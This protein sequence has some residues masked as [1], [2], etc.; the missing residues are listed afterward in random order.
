MLGVAGTTPA[1]PGGHGLLAMATRPWRPELCSLTPGTLCKEPQ[2]PLQ[3]LEL[4]KG[5]NT[6]EFLSIS[7]SIWEVGGR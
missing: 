4:A 6:D 2:D 1:F 7:P 3:S 5:R